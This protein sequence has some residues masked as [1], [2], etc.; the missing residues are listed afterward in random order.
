MTSFSDLWWLWG[1]QRWLSPPKSWQHRSVLYCK[2]GHDVY[3]IG[4]FPSYCPARPDNRGSLFIEMPSTNFTH[5]RWTLK[6]SYFQYSQSKLSIA[7]S[8]H[9]RFFFFLVLPAAPNSL[10]RIEAGMFGEHRQPGR[11]EQIDK[12]VHSVS[13][14]ILEPP[15][16]ASGR[17]GCWRD[18]WLAGWQPI[19]PG[20]DENG[21]EVPADSRGHPEMRWGPLGGKLYSSPLSGHHLRRTINGWRR[22]RQHLKVTF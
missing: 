19:Y 5:W 17:P 15:T 12:V 9:L 14:F 1:S 2:Q 10:R 6:V 21:R 22:R 13:V 18:S 7:N 16:V 4:I 3:R 20:E 8:H 11:R